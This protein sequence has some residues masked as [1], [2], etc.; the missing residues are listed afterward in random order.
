MKLT[1]Q[2]IR[3]LGGNYNY[4][5]STTSKKRQYRVDVGPEY[6]APGVALQIEAESLQNAILEARRI[7]DQTYTSMGWEVIQVHDG[8][9]I[10]WDYVNGRLEK[11]P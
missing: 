11:T 1:K 6:G 10:V 3:D 2:G 4:R 5:R 7:L 8:R 9:D